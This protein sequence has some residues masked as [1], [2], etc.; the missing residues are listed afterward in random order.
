MATL[1]PIRDHILFQ[2]EE[3]KTKH[4]GIDQ[5]QEKTD[6]GFT[7]A[8][9]D[10]SLETGRWGKVTHIG[11]EVKEIE[12]GMRVCVDKLMWSNEFIFEDQSYW[13]TEEDHI[14]MIDED[15]A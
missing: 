11:P 7:Y 9:T 14:L 4:M 13:R 3:G 12:V 2:F 6:W 8:Q 10:S 5:F 15:V 1:R